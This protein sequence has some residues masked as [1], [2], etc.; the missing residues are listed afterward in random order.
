MEELERAINEELGAFAKPLSTN[1]ADLTRA[2]QKLIMAGLQ[3][4]DGTYK[5]ALTVGAA[6]ATGT[7]LSD[8]EHRQELI[9]AVTA[10]DIITAAGD[11]LQPTRSVTSF[12]LV[13]R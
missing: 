13:D 1:P 5:S 6:L 8:I 10:D 3:A 9:S 12:L 7:S 11:L 2:K 4:R